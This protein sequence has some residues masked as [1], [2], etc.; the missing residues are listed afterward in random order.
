M[1][2]LTG[3]DEVAY[4]ITSLPADLAGPLPDLWSQRVLPATR[5]RSGNFRLVR[6]S[7]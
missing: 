1:T 6:S 7:A 4:G 5:A 2:R 3:T